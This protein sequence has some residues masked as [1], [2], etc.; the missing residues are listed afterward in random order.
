[1]GEV[2]DDHGLSRAVGSERDDLGARW[3]LLGCFQSKSTSGLKVPILVLLIRY[4]RLLRALLRSSR[5]MRFASQ[6]GPRLSQSVRRLS[7][8]QL[9]RALAQRLAGKCRL[10][11]GGRLAALGVAVQF[12]E[13]LCLVGRSCS[14][15]HLDK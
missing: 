14:G 2:L 5:S 7:Q 3:I 6:L 13:V 9:G 11:P 15:T 12:L 4:S 8:S 1:M 10:T